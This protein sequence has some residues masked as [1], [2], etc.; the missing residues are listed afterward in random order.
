MRGPCDFLDDPNQ[1]RFYTLERL[2]GIPDFVKN[3]SALKHREGVD[4][5]PGHVFGDSRRR[6]FPCHT[7][8]ATWLAQAYFTLCQEGY[9]KKEAAFIQARIEKAAEHFGISGLVKAFR[10]NWDRVSG[11]NKQA[12]DEKDCALVVDYGGRKVKMFPMPN[13][14]S[15]KLAGEY[16][17]ANRFRYPYPWRKTAA[18]NILRKA[19][20]YDERW[21]KG[22]KIAG[23]DLGAL[24]FG[25]DTREY[26]EKAAGIGASF[27]EHVAE[28]V[29]QRVMMLG[30]RHKP[31]KIKLAKVAKTIHA[32]PVTACTPAVLQKTAAAIDAID[33][34][35]GI[36]NHYH[37]GVELPEEALFQLVAKQAQHIKEGFITLTT[38]NTYPVEALKHLPLDKIASVMGQ[39]LVDA[40]MAKDGMSVDTEKAAEILPTLPRTDASLL[41]KVISEAADEELNKT[42]GHNKLQ[43][44][45]YTKL[46]GE[47]P[48]SRESMLEFFRKKGHSPRDIRYTM[49]VPVNRISDK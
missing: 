18:R 14:I 13:P 45:P 46:P 27:P 49:A 25:A 33:R 17:F 1:Q 26:L 36:C 39:E 41:E 3:A 10:R 15:V 42:A 4:Q 22:E 23:A 28:K 47:D 48:F 21:K 37:H 11:M 8:A 20:E 40:I 24:R 29:A 9:S 5:L 2:H 6:K 7:K 44:N 43:N 30:E 19:N 34:E 32:M 31:L 38:G 12:A 16:L 35:S